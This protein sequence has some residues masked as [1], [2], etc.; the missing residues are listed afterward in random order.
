MYQRTDYGIADGP[1][2]ISAGVCV[3]YNIDDRVQGGSEEALAPIDDVSP[4][5]LHGEVFQRSDIVTIGEDAELNAELGRGEFRGVVQSIHVGD[6]AID[7]AGIVGGEVET[8]LAG[9]D[10]MSEFAVNGYLLGVLTGT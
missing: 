4:A 9:L 8:A 3:A 5:L 6:Q 2:C 10:P 7:D 1:R